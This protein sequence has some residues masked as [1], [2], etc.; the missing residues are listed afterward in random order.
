MHAG[1]YG[2]DTTAQKTIRFINLTKE[3]KYTMNTWKKKLL[4][5]LTIGKNKDIAVKKDRKRRIGP[6]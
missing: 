4:K 3:K 1:P 2:V 5:M 6:K